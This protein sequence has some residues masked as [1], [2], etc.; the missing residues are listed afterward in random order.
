MNAMGVITNPGIIGFI[1]LDETG[2]VIG[3]AYRAASEGPMPLAL[4]I[5]D[6]EIAQILCADPRPDVLEAGF[7]RER[8]GFRFPIPALYFDGTSH[9][10]QLRDGEGAPISFRTH[11]GA[12][13]DAWIFSPHREYPAT[14]LDPWL[15]GDS[16]CWAVIVDR[17]TGSARPADYVVVSQSGRTITTLFPTIA[18]PDAA[19]RFAC[20]ELC[21]FVLPYYRIEMLG[22]TAPLTFRVFP[23]GR[24]IQGSPLVLPALEA[25]RPD[26]G[27]DQKP[28]NIAAMAAAG[29]FDAAYYLHA[30]PD[31]AQ[32][33]ID[34][35]NHYF[36]FGYREGRWPNLYFDTGWYQAQNPELEATDREPLMSFLLHGDAQGRNPSPLFDAQWYRKHYDV[37][38]D[39]NTLSHYLRLRF[40]TPLSPN[41][42]FDA[43]YYAA[44]YPD[45]FAAK[46]MLP[47]RV[48]QAPP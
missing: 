26:V 17:L 48:R 37:P 46:V 14:Q 10:V 1:E 39:E 34:P 40:E 33:G 47:G 21:G 5:D 28:E 4:V 45:V 29:L 16:H 3:W 19:A 27:P 42:D 12:E 43:D 30:Y 38:E 22:D 15:G 11:D 36:N 20:D 6:Q 41:P 35:S 13:Q 31:I 24:E 32:A 8:V 18:R 7:A 25:E 44:K 9:N 2:L 23:D